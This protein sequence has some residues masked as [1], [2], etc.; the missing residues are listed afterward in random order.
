MTSRATTDTPSRRLAAIIV[1]AGGGTRMGDGL[2]KQFRSIRGRS[3]LAHAVAAFIDHPATARIVI[4]AAAD[5]LA[6]AAEAIGDL[7]RDD[8]VMIVTGGARR[9]D[10][11]AAGLAAAADPGINLV[12]IHDAARPF[13]PQ[14]V[15]DDLI[16]VLDGGADA[17]LPVLP[18]VDTVKLVE[19][20]RVADTIE[21]ANLGRAQTPQMFRLAELIARHEA[22]PFGKE[23]TDDIRLFEDG[24]S[25]I[26]TVPGDECLMK[27]TQPA[28]FAMLSAMLHPE[29]DAPVPAAMPPFDIRTGNG[30]DVHK[31]GDGD[32]PV[33]LG[34]VDIAHDRSL[35]AHSDGDV[36]L[37]ALCD[38]IFG[39]LADG[40]IGSH[41]PPSDTRWKNAD[42][43]QFL[44][45]AASRCAERGAAILHLDLT[46]ICENPKIGPHRD[47]MRA[48]IAQ[49]VGI[50]IS[51]VAVKATTSEQLGFTGRGEGIAAQA[52]ATLAMTGEPE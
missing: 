2:E 5:S 26:E 13:L 41:F 43:A 36:G 47:A 30:Y 16:A 10:S 38:A 52:T 3:V 31:F 19:D 27:L 29:G 42:S 48:R 11:V 46:L 18:V 22:L 20:N 14:C 28:D 50:D 33:R 32:G 25:R 17:A 49:L 34:G 23:I 1:A 44:D 40:D 45:F 4:V 35:A 21:R 12:A 6:K 37:H 7:A 15:I 8:R 51:R 9:Q 39:A 24:T